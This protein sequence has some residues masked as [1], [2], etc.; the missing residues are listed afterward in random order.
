ML[1]NTKPEI[2]QSSTTTTTTT[3]T[4]VA[5]PKQKKKVKLIIKKKK[6][7]STDT[8]SEPEVKKETKTKKKTKKLIIKPKPKSVS[9]TDSEA[10]TEA[11]AEP[12]P[13]KKKV[14]KKKTVKPTKKST[15]KKVVIDTE[16]V[17]SEPE[18][19][20]AEAELEN[21]EPEKPLRILKYA[22][23]TI[24][25]DRAKRIYNMPNSV[26]FGHI[27]VNPEVDGLKSQTDDEYILDLKRLMNKHLKKGRNPIKVQYSFSKEMVDNG[28]IYAKGVSLQRMNSKVRGYLC[29][30]YYYDLDMV[31]AQPSMLHYILKKYYPNQKFAFIK[32]YIKNRDVVLSKLHEDRAEAKKIII[33]SM[34][35]SKRVSSLSKSFLVGLDDDFKRAQNLIWSHPCE[36]TEGLVKYKATCKQNAKGKYMNKVLCV[37]ENMLLH[38]AINQFDDQYI[39]TMIMDGF[40]I[41]KKVPMPLSEIL[42]RCNK[43]SHEYGVVWAHKKFNTDLDFLDD[44]DLTDENDNSYDTVKI[45]FEKTHFIIKNP[46]MF[47]REYMFEGSPTYGLHNKNDFMALCKEWTYTDTLPDGTAMEFDMFNKWLADKSKRSYK[48]LNFIPLTSQIIKNSLEEQPAGSDQEI[49]TDTES[50]DDM[51]EMVEFETDENSD[52][53]MNE[54]SEDE[55][56]ALLNEEEEDEK[57][58]FLPDSEDS[59]DEDHEPEEKERLEYYN[60]FRGFDCEKLKYDYKYD[61]TAVEVFRK[62]LSH[63]TDHDEASI[64]YLM[65]YFADIIQNPSKPPG[66]AILIKS[67]QGYGKDMTIDIVE[68]MI[69]SAYLCRTEDIKDVLGS[70]NTPIKDKI[71]CVI[72]ELQGKDG[73]EYKD[74]LKGIITSNTLNINEKGIKHYKQSNNLRFF[75]FSNRMN[76]IEISQDDRR[77]VV[78]KSSFRKYRFVNHLF[79]NNTMDE[80]FNKSKNE[81][82]N[83][84]ASGSTAIPTKYFMDGFLKYRD[85]NQIEDH[86]NSFKEI[87]KLLADIGVE[88][89]QMKFDGRG[90]RFYCFNK[91]DVIGALEPMNI[92]DEYQTVDMDEWD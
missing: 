6:S 63:L 60:T 1:K 86:T 73:W 43:S 85:E 27:D 57:G 91:L 79:I 68:K 25:M 44:E 5:P 74:K 37:M 78:F 76:P 29:S 72:N 39:S 18:E 10:E 32:S 2:A 3:N 52:V 38:K 46:L 58:E 64:E 82:R 30:K 12:E 83:H 14:N 67:P 24:D 33:I 89:K 22:D 23:E 51:G 55:A 66:I 87:K 35:S 19:L 9:T 47:G 65:S 26:L 20:D 62:H 42:E 75:I 41:S 13:I 54:N 4:T 48:K 61:P 81:Y 36:F 16:P 49:D 71:I 11:E 8:E 50:D 34:N 88:Q 80:Y 21:M 53:I 45:K 17:G 92:V 28:R 69:S 84:K 70:F 31:N 40:H 77:F 59:E 90:D 56:E 7:I 15:K